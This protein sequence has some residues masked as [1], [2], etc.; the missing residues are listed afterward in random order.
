MKNTVYKAART[1]TPFDP[2]QGHGDIEAYLMEDYNPNLL[3]EAFLDNLHDDIK[4]L[5]M[6]MATKTT[7]MPEIVSHAQQ[8]WLGMGKKKQEQRK[9]TEVLAINSAQQGL[10]LEGTSPHRP[11]PTHPPHNP[12]SPQHPK[13]DRFHHPNQ[14]RGP[15]RSPRSPRSPRP[16]RSPRRDQW[17]TISDQL[18]RILDI[19]S[20]QEDTRN[21]RTLDPAPHHRQ[22]PPH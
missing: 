5:V 12:R 19:M 6:A 8:I 2:Q 15:P 16:P 4:G 1:I 22:P 3:R 11:M 20:S 9:T 14:G 17:D 18:R 21:S 13:R 10:N 7:S